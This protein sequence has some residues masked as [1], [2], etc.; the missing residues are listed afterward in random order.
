[1]KFL[2]FAAFLAVL[3]LCAT[4]RA[5]EPIDTMELLP[6]GWG[7]VFFDVKVIDADEYGLT[8]RHQNGAAKVLYEWLPL[9]V[10]EKYAPMRSGKE[11]SSSG[12]SGGF[13]VSPEGAAAGPLVISVLNRVNLPQFSYGNP[14]ACYPWGGVALPTWHSHWPRYHPAHALV[15]PYYRSLAVQDFLYSSN[16]VPRPIWLTGWN[17]EHRRPRLFYY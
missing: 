9:E 17:L 15:N 5:D 7:E 3:A 10:E 1:M 2:N 14:G 16:L 8:F 12:N 4:G 13:Q 11:A 6:V